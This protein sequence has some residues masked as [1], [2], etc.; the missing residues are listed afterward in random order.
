MFIKYN[1]AHIS[2]LMEFVTIQLPVWKTWPSI[3][4]VKS[5]KQGIHSG[6]LLIGPSVAIYPQML[7]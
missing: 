4:D 1:A 7:F 2:S 5:H 6:T 3:R